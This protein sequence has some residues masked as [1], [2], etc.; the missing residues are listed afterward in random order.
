MKHLQIAPLLLSTFLLSPLANAADVTASQAEGRLRRAMQIAREQNDKE[1]VAEVEATGR[2]VMAV[3]RAGKPEGVDAQLRTVEVQ[4]GLDG[5]GNSMAGQ[6]LFTPT[7]EMLEKSK[8]FGAKLGAAMQSGD[9]AQVSAVT[10]EML[11]V[12]GDQAGVPDGRRAGKK[13]EP[14]A[15]TEGAASKLFLDALDGESRRIRPILEGKPLPDQMVRIYA[16]VL[17]AANS[18]R[19]FAAKHQPEA[20]ANLDRLTRGATRILLDLQQPAGHFPFPDLRGKNIRF[21]DLTEKLLQEGK[22]EARDG[23]LVTPDPDGGSQFDTGLSGAALLAAGKLHSRDEWK[24]AG[25]R[26]ADWALTQPCCSNFNYNA[27]SVSLL[28]QA[29]RSTGEPKYLE[30]ALRKFRVGVAPGQAPNGR[31]IDPH[32]AR[33]V[34][35]VI[36]LRALADL[37]AALPPDRVAER[38]E[39]EQITRPAI[40]ALLTEFDAMGITVEALPELLALAEAL[41]EDARLRAATQ[42]MSASIVAKCT[43][44]QRVKM[45]AQPHQLATVPAAAAW[46]AR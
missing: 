27:F 11:R 23:W 4:V 10:V 17:D 19:P 9:P 14:R 15:I 39:V 2:R 7:P 41:P 26:A 31:W 45:G 6:P 20:L 24:R 28:A 32:N 5:G 34:Y 46:L 13:V 33:T 3:L 35:H 16:Y 29:F 30:G 37:R 36:I 1:L 21:G 8:A 44:G 40:T 42:S 25:L 38:G 43:D 18:A 12:L 22:V